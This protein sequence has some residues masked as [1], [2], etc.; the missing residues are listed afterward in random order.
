MFSAFNPSEWSSGQPTLRRP[1][2]SW[3]FGALL[4]G[5]T[6]VV[7]TS[8]SLP[9]RAGIRTHNLG[10]PQVS[11]P[12]LYPLGHNCPVLPVLAQ[13]RE[14]L[15]DHRDLVLRH[16]SQLGLRVNWKKS[17]LSPVQRISFL[18]GE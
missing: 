3:G 6:S 11:S 17:N 8:F 4:K 9:A 15:G 5:L 1:G 13:S 12:T 10:L 18:G 14:Q 7:D 2:N 16:L